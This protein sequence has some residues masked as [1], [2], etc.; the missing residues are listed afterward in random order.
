MPR[1]EETDS[2]RDFLESIKSSEHIRQLGKITGPISALGVAN[3]I[4]TFS[5]SSPVTT[6]ILTRGGE[7]G[8]IFVKDRALHAARPGAVTGLKAVV[9]MMSWEEGNFEFEASVDGSITGDSPIPVE[10]VLAEGARQLDEMR[11]PTSE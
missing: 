6:L 9:R 3:L 4:R 11:L 5:P 10:V 2:V 7:Q 1:A 8:M